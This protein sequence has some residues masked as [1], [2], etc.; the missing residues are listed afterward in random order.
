MILKYIF[1]R[2]LIILKFEY[3]FLILSSKNFHSIKLDE[4]KNRQK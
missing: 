4:S 1:P 3:R 2:I